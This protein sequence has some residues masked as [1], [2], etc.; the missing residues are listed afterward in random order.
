M[1]SDPKYSI[2]NR[3]VRGPRCSLEELNATAVV[4]NYTIT[5]IWIAGLGPGDYRDRNNSRCCW[6]FPS[7]SV[8]L[9]SCSR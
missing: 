1:T 3:L 6:Y 4:G 2:R 5:G 7:I 8:C 9:V